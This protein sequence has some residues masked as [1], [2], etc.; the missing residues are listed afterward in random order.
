MRGLDRHYIKK[1]KITLSG[2]F[3]QNIYRF[4]KCVYE[5]LEI[6]NECDVAE[7]CMMY[8]VLFDVAYCML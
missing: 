5:C 2:S 8:S 3:P 6:R 1:V 7:L 4:D